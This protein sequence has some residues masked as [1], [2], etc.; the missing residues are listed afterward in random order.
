MASTAAVV[1]GLRDHS[2]SLVALGAIGLLDGAASTVLV[3]HFRHALR[4]EAPAPGRERLALRVV[5]TGMFVVAMATG[6]ESVH[7]L[8][9]DAAGH[10]VQAGAV[11]AGLSVVALTSLSRWKRRVAK[12]IGSQALLADS[13]LSAVG[14]GLAAVTVAGTAL[15]E[16]HSWVDPAAGLVIALGAALLAVLL[17]REEL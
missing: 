2:L 4:H 5:T 7:R 9:G 1:L 8:L 13:W 12:E 15:A 16:R 14:A 6:A 17:S 10:E 3:L 11:L